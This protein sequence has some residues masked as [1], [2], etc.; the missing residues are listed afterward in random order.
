[1]IERD[2]VFRLKTERVPGTLGRVLTVI[3][4]FGAQVGEI[5]TLSIGHD[6]NVREVTASVAAAVASPA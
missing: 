1:M 6:Y 2:E 5:A 4:S 3:G